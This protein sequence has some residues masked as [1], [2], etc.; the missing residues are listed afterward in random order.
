ML[1]AAVFHVLRTRLTHS[2]IC[3]FYFVMHTT[4]TLGRR[5]HLTQNRG[6]RSLFPKLPDDYYSRLIRVAMSHQAWER[7]ASLVASSSAPTLPRA[8]GEWL[9]RLL[10][11][12]DSSSRITVRPSE[13]TGPHDVLEFVR[14]DQEDWQAW[15]MQ[16]D[17]ALLAASAPERWRTAAAQSLN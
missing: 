2:Y 17:L 14:A 3:V 7:L 15:Q 11:N 6:L 1:T 13:Q 8:Y 4:D 10:A 16:K 12:F 5:R 9:E